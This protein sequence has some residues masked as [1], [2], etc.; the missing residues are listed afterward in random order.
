MK[1]HHQNL[2]EIKEFIKKA[3]QKFDEEK[4][5]LRAGHHEPESIR[6][7][8]PLD[9]SITNWW[10]DNISSIEQ[11]DWNTPQTFL[12]PLIRSRPSF[13][14]SITPYTTELNNRHL[15]WDEIFPDQNIYITSTAPGLS[16]D[17]KIS[18]TPKNP[19]LPKPSSKRQIP[20]SKDHILSDPKINSSISHECTRPWHPKTHFFLN[21][22][23]RAHSSQRFGPT[24][25]LTTPNEELKKIWL[26]EI[27]T[28]TPVEL[29]FKTL[30]TQTEFSPSNNDTS[31][32]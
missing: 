29:W 18:S 5:V 17:I 2:L 27:T 16:T 19:P 20:K 8:E 11:L 23:I 32:N 9:H 21:T 26:R 6:D 14:F 30:A 1:R 24:I 31:M 25:T 7:D 28:Y 22:S 15:K 3:Q 10:W 4:S 12:L 13:P